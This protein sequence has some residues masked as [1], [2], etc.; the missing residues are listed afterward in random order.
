[1][2][3]VFTN[4]AKYRMI[5]RGI[6]AEYVRQTIKNPE[7]KRLDEYGMIIARKKFNNNILEIV[8]RLRG[9]TYVII[10]LYYEN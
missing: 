4:H 7:Q 3:I 2:K 1:M 8:Y 10:T 6:P 9:V 5:E